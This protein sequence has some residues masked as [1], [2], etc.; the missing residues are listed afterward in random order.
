M[1][2]RGPREPRSEGDAV[3]L[4]FAVA[5]ASTLAGICGACFLQSGDRVCAGVGSYGMG[6]EVRDQL[7]R[8][9]AFGSRVTFSDLNDGTSEVVSESG[10]SL[11]LYGLEDRAGA[12]H[13]FDVKVEHPY[14]ATSTVKGVATPRVGCVTRDVSVLV[15]TTLSLQAGAPP[16]R[17]MKLLPT[18]ALLDRPPIPPSVTFRPWIDANPGVSQAVTWTITG[19]TAS[20]TFDQSLGVVT[21]R[22]KPASGYLYIRAQSVMNPAVFDSARI[23]VQGHPAATGDPPCS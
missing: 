16:V 1:S 6:V 15:T 7:G 4:R 21:Y 9:A 17:Y 12:G 3:K 2:T 11:R 8:A 5:A 20:V 14:Y 22:C 10:D 13:T 19:D 23:A 18:Y